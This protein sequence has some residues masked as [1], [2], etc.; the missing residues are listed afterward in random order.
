MTAPLPSPSGTSAAAMFTRIT[1]G[2][3]EVPIGR[4]V[5]RLIC[6]AGT[7]SADRT[8]PVT[9]MKI[10]RGNGAE[11]KARALHH[12]STQPNAASSPP[13]M[14][15]WRRR[16]PA[17]SIIPQKAAA[18]PQQ[19]KANHCK[20]L[21]RV[22]HAAMPTPNPTGIHKPSCSRSDS[23]PRSTA[24][25]SRRPLPA[26]IRATDV[27]RGSK[28]MLGGVAFMIEQGGCRGIRR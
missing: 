12:I 17:G 4:I 9:S 27:C 11:P 21:G 5:T 25:K 8:S 28:A 26:R 18:I 1:D 10:G 20:A 3:A 14:I 16:P 22:I 13:N 19:Q 15:D 7:A 2:R 24:M 23:S 6:C